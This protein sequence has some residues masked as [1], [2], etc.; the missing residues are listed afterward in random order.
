[1]KDKYIT[2]PFIDK[3]IYFL[4]DKPEFHQSRFYNT[5]LYC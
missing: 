3:D 5:L 4:K 2:K 1:M